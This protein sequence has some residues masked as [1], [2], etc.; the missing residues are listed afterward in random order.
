MRMSPIEIGLSFLEGL[1]L[2]ASPCILPVLPLM[3]A[4]SLEGG[5]QRPLGIII[6]FVS[7]FTLFAL[8]SRHLVMAF[9]IDLDSIKYTSLVF[10][11]L[12]G[13]VLFSEK[14]SLKFSALTQRFANIGGHLAANAKKRFR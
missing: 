5:R 1:A 4:G 2:I 8:L 3:L 7:A 13:L 10:L 11:L 14:L 6:G 9:H 12:F